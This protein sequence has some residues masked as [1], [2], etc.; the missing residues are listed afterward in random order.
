MNAETKEQKRIPTVTVKRIKSDPR[1]K[2]EWYELAGHRNRKLIHTFTP[3]VFEDENIIP[4][5]LIKNLPDTY[6]SNELYNLCN[7]FGHIE[8]YQYE[9]L[10]NIGSI[11]FSLKNRSGKIPRNALL[12]LTGSI[13]KNK[14][15]K[16]EFDRD[17]LKFKELSKKKKEEIR[18]KKENEK[19]KAE[20]IKKN[21]QEN[22]QKITI[23][24]SENHKNEDEKK[25]RYSFSKTQDNS[26]NNN[27]YDHDSKK[28]SSNKHSW[29][30][31]KNHK[32]SNEQTDIT[33]YDSKNE[34]NGYD[35]YYYKNERKQSDTGL[36]GKEKLDKLQVAD[37]LKQI[38]MEKAKLQKIINEKE[39][40]IK[41][42]E[43]IDTN[44]P[45]KINKDSF[46]FIN[47]SFSL[48]IFCNFAFSISI[49]FNRSATCNLSSF[50]FPNKPV[51]LCF[52]SF[53]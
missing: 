3:V 37:R 12:T 24:T 42:N 11:T 36:F 23:S 44:N 49:C 26:E 43:S 8:N 15:I 47:A 48:I 19:K 2:F 46:F 25:S 31:E 32:H 9:S 53:L 41:K 22:K 29:N 4:T 20:E 39:A 10:C 5:L 28:Q 21:E 34:K 27:K 33:K 38:E 7:G 40:L 14:H 45:T 50:S 35:R 52:L 13:V 6:S 17:G 18:L 16:V 1:K 51:S 30:D